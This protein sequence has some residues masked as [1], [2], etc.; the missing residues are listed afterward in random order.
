M[1]VAR[2]GKMTG[3]TVGNTA[4]RVLSRASTQPYSVT[5]TRLSVPTY[6]SKWFLSITQV[7]DSAIYATCRIPIID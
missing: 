3:S 5:S 6:M 4:R 7:S 1:A 2:H